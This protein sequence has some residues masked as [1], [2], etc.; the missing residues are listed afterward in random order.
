[1][2][3]PC[4]VCSRQYEQCSLL[5]YL[6]GSVVCP[7]ECML[8]NWNSIHLQR[9]EICCTLFGSNTPTQEAGPPSD[10]SHWFSPCHTNGA[11]WLF[12][13][14]CLTSTQPCMSPRRPVQILY[15]WMK[16]IPV[17]KVTTHFY[18]YFSS[19]DQINYCPCIDLLLLSEFCLSC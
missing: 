4:A 9:L 15:P 1:M 18:L 5:V 12:G 2:L 10:R 7:F 17:Q 3:C 14:S 8:R 11:L 6:Y 19:R 13:Q 16:F